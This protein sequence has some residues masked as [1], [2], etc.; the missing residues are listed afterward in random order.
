MDENGINDVF[1]LSPGQYPFV[2]TYHLY[3]YNRWGEKVFDSDVKEETWNSSRTLQGVY[4]YVVVI[5]DI[6]DV[7]RTIKGTVTVLK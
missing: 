3:I 6:Y 2:K 7:T 5:K 1:G 4:V